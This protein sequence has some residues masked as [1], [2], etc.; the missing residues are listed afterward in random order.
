MI[1]IVERT[2]DVFYSSVCLCEGVGPKQQI[3]SG[4]ILVLL[5]FDSFVITLAYGHRHSLGS[6]YLIKYSFYSPM[7]K[8]ILLDY[9]CE[10]DTSINTTAPNTMR[11]L[12]NTMAYNSAYNRLLWFQLMLLGVT[13]D[14]VCAE[15]QMIHMPVYTCPSPSILFVHGMILS[16]NQYNLK[17]YYHNHQ[18]Q[19]AS[20]Q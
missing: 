5:K 9:I 13:V 3:Y 4:N 18:L 20:I 7:I 6:T 14:G 10:T 17:L 15:L 12:S 16:I 1:F 19:Q 2:C 8:I 11:L